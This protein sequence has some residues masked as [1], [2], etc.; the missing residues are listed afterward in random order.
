MSLTQQ[1]QRVQAA[2][3]T[4]LPVPWPG[5]DVQLVHAGPEETT[6]LLLAELGTA[7]LA[8]YE[9]NTSAAIIQPRVFTC[10][11]LP[12]EQAVQ[13][14]LGARQHT[15]RPVPPGAWP[16]QTP[17]RAPRDVDLPQQ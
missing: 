9:T 12:A 16:A 4:L 8:V 15:H 14:L 7:R 10:R 2:G 3:F 1:I 13:Q 11:D 17:P 6:I 5:W